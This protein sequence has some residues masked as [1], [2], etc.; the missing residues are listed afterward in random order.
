[1]E[2]TPEHAGAACA[3]LLYTSMLRPLG[4]SLGEA[5]ALLVPALAELP[6]H[7]AADPLVRAFDELLAKERA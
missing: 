1:M 4:D 7:D 6:M 5:G 3:S 2:M